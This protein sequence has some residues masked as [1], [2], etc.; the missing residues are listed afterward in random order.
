M[1]LYNKTLHYVI[2]KAANCDSISQGNVRVSYQSVSR[3]NGLL[4]GTQTFF[5]EDPVRLSAGW[6]EK[7]SF[8]RV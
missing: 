4:Y 1:E 5:L 8:P 7:D 2:I 6:K 3:F